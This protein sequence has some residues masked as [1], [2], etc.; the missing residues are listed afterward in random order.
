[1]GARS[2]M[3]HDIQASVVHGFANFLEERFQDHQAPPAVQRS[4]EFPIKNGEDYA[5]W[6][7]THLTPRWLLDI[8]RAIDD[9][10]DVVFA[11]AVQVVCGK[12]A[13]LENGAVVNDENARHGAVGLKPFAIMI[14]SAV[15]SP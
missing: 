12:P 9:E 15:P 13:S 5:L 7:V 11:H 2:A 14:H 8:R 1:M 6:G 10:A 3:D 4:A